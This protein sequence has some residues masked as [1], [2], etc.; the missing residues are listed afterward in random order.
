MTQARVTIF[1][2]LERGFNTMENNFNID[3]ASA[4]LN[5]R[6]SRIIDNLNGL[7]SFLECFAIDTAANSSRCLTR[8]D[9]LG[10]YENI[11]PLIAS[12]VA[13]NLASLRLFAS[14]MDSCFLELSNSG[15][16]DCYDVE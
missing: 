2:Y 3:T 7:D 16:G 10:Y 9:L 12:T 15:K 4:D 5:H 6:I 13:N 1:R 8:Q 14:D 11:Y